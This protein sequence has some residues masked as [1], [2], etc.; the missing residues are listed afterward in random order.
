MHFNGAPPN[1]KRIA[2]VNL[3]CSKRHEELR[4]HRESQ[5][6]FTKRELTRFDHRDQRSDGRV[7]LPLDFLR[8]AIARGV[9]CKFLQ[10]QNL[11]RKVR[12]YQNISVQIDVG[13]QLIFKLGRR[14]HVTV[15]KTSAAVTFQE[16]EDVV[17]TVEPVIFNRPSSA[18][19]VS[20]QMMLH[21]KFERGIKH[22]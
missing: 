16:S 8:I 20:E 10:V 1:G 2:K 13:Q 15:E 22:N 11:I 3:S 4:G 12:L 17:P 7:C 5:T 9:L 18:L 19:N 14:V 21:L 6:V